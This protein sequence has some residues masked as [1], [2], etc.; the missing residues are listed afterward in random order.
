M[1]LTLNFID[2]RTPSVNISIIDDDLVEHPE[3]IYLKLAT[4]ADS[5]V[6]LI[7][8]TTLIE[9]IDDDCK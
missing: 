5:G 4:S 9:I 6:L 3:V 1:N 2:E 8:N 7:S